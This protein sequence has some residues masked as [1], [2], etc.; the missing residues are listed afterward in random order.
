MASHHQRAMRLPELTKPQW[1]AALD[2][3]RALMNGDPSSA[4]D[5]AAY[6]NARA[7]LA[8][9]LPDSADANDIIKAAVRWDMLNGLAASLAMLPAGAVEAIP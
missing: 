3:A 2:A 4:T 8:D 1:D 7:Q 9:L 6:R 5:R